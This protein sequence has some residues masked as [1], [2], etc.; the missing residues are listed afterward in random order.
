V[1]TRRDR[2]RHRRHGGRLNDHRD[3]PGQLIAALNLTSG[4]TCRR[5]RDPGRLVAFLDR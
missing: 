1:G 3:R 5:L 2:L 4:A